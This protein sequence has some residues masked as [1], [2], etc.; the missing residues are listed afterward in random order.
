MAKRL[1]KEEYKP[2]DDKKKQRMLDKANSKVNK[3]YEK[4]EEDDTYDPRPEYKKAFRMQTVSQGEDTG[5]RKL[6]NP[7]PKKGLRPNLRRLEKKNELDDTKP[8]F[9]G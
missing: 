1:R 8:G 3:A 6:G 4:E 9:R 7:D 5:S 2:L